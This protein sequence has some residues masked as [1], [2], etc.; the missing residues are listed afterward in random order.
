[1]L[2]LLVITR[3]GDEIVVPAHEGRSLMENLRQA[4]V[5]EVLALFAEDA[6]R[7]P[8]ATSI[9]T[10]LSMASHLLSVRM[11]EI[12]LNLRATAPNTPD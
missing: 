9:L 10:L 8:R 6:A 5:D 2:N 4:G 3:S 12:C 7:V 11:R 1:M